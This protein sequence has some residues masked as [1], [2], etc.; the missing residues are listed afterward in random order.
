M[1]EMQ[2]GAKL[3]RLG[4]D[5]YESIMDLWRRS[6]LTSLKP[7][8]R[9]SRQAFAQ[10][11]ASGVQ[12]VLGLEENGRLI[13]VVVATHDSR[14]GWVN[15][16]TVDPDYRRQGYARRLLAAAEEL[17]KEQGLFI[18][19]ALIEDWNEASLTLF[20][21]AG[22]RLNDDVYYLSKRASDDV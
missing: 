10:Q 1:D 16:L 20:L 19:V 7:R 5:D 6:G 13:A 11:L 12:T 8:G 3:R 22:Y 4:L 14:K 17:F 21:Q 9:D 18:T 15:R 2:P